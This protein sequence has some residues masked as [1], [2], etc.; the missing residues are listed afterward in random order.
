MA[1]W[2]L[3]AGAIIEYIVSEDKIWIDKVFVR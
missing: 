2:N 3:K 1:G